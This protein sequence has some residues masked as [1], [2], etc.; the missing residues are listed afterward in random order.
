MS[1]CAQVGILMKIGITAARLGDHCV[2]ISDVYSGKYRFG[3]RVG[4]VA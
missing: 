4:P 2:Q 3:K 1:A